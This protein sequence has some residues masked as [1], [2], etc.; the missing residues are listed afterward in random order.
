MRRVLCV[1]C[2]L[3]LGCRLEGRAPGV[4]VEVKRPSLRGEKLRVGDLLLG[5]TLVGEVRP[6][7]RL[8]VY[9]H[10][11]NQSQYK[12]FNQVR[13]GNK[14][15][16]YLISYLRVIGRVSSLPVRGEYCLG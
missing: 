4:G 14:T 16:Q 11:C 8:H 7:Y 15:Y 2:G 13:I 5:L 12:Q 10:K 6:V 1:V 3:G 9:K